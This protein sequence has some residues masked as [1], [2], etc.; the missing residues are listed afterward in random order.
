VDWGCVDALHLRRFRYSDGV[1][2]GF[3]ELSV[4]KDSGSSAGDKSR[5]NEPP[6]RGLMEP[7]KG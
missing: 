4:A 5:L 3:G 2:G 6:N 7:A 1:F